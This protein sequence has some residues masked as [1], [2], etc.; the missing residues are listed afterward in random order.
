MKEYAISIL[1][2]AAFS[3]L[4][5]FMIK[6]IFGWRSKANSSEDSDRH[7]NSRFTKKFFS[8]MTAF[9]IVAA[10]LLVY[11]YVD[12]T[13]LFIIERFFVLSVLWV[14]A[15]YDLKYYIIPNQIIIIGLASRIVLWGFEFIFEREGL[16]LLVLEQLITAAALVV[17]GIVF[18]III[19][20]GIGMGDIKLFAVLALFFGT[21]GSLTAI[22]VALIFSFFVSLFFIIFKKA[23]KKDPIPFGPCAL[24][25]TYIAVIIF[26][27]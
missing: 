21:R 15:Y 14:S 10:I 26:G 27:V 20:N 13:L 24:A 17:V 5:F 23:S 2:S 1:A 25:G 11:F 9:N 4:T 6:L 7:P 8:I 3:A 22:F 18:S 12:N 16:G 19:K